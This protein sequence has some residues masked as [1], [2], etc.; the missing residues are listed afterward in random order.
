MR[1]EAKSDPLRILI[2]DDSPTARALLCTI[3]EGDPRVAV[4]G[5]ARDG[6]EAVA[7]TARLRPSVVILDIHMPGCSGLEATRRLRRLD[8][9]AEVPIIAMTANAY[10]ED[11]IACL[12]AGMDDHLAK[13]VDPEL[14]YAML[15]RW[16]PVR[17][18]VA[19]PDADELRRSMAAQPA[20]ARPPERFADIPGLAMSRALL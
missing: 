6:L 1:K 4:V 9:Y 10:G 8:G 2:A 11:R 12:A 3:F 18:G 19:L 16:L 14:L 15:E 7:L 20:G 13:P 5:Q 17:E